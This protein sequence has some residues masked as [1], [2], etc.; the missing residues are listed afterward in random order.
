MMK[1][2]NK[3]AV[4]LA[5]LLV[6]STLYYQFKYYEFTPCPKTSTHVVNSLHYD[7]E[8][9][10]KAEKV[11]ASRKLCCPKVFIYDPRIIEDKANLHHNKPLKLHHLDPLNKRSIYDNFSYSGNSSVDKDMRTA[12]LT[13]LLLWSPDAEHHNQS[14]II[15]SPNQ[16]ARIFYSKDFVNIFNFRVSISKCVTT[17]PREAE[18][19]L[20]PMSVHTDHSHGKSKLQSEEWD[21]FFSKLT[22][23]QL[24]FEH[25]NEKTAS[26]HVIFSSS[27]GHS[28]KSLGLWHPPFPDPRVSQMQRVALGSQCLI[29]YSYRY[30]RYIFQTANYF[31]STPFSSLMSYPENYFQ[32]KEKKKYLASVFV[33]YHGPS[34]VQRMRKKL[35]SLCDAD[36]SCVTDTFVNNKSSVV[37]RDRASVMLDI[38]EVKTQSTFCFEP[39]GDW[40]TRQSMV[41]DIMLNCIPVFFST[42]HLRLWPAF[43]GN[44]IER[45]SVVVQGSKVLSGEVD[46]M[47]VLRS[48]SPE[49][50]LDKQR[51]MQEYKHQFDFIHMDDFMLHGNNYNHSCSAD[52][53]NLL[54]HELKRSSLR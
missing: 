46:L 14:L 22:D 18:L 51:A 15:P 47:Q 48:V 27:F 41:Q 39:E 43:W 33:G 45:A 11:K 37:Y 24:I 4:L 35:F 10:T 34:R 44:F 2:W 36:A 40:P 54:L 49:V 12:V 23:Y 7:I 8:V 31:H 16:D 5:V 30:F 1:W 50:V 28:R 53:S 20:V 3:Y 13:Q 21:K 17:D 29:E 26:K 52:A 9:T 32:P 38:F 6:I 42:A 25:F 19:F